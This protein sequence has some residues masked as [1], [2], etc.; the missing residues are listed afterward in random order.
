MRGL[1]S[2]LLGLALVVAVPWVASAQ[3]TLAGVVRDSSGAVL[4]GVTVEASS[5]VLIEKARTALTDDA[6]RYQIID[7]RPGIYTVTFTLT[8]FIVVRRDGVELTGTAVTTANADLRV[9]GVQETITVTGETP[10]VDL[11]ST[12]RQT[13]MGQEI[14]TAIPTSRNS[15]AVAVLI[16]AV[17]VSNGFGP[18]QDVGGALG[19]T[20]LAL[21]AHGSRVSDQRLMVNGVALSTMI[22]GGWG[23]GAIPNATGTAEF[24]IDT[25]AVDAT[26]ATGGVR[27]NFIPRDG[28]NRFSGTIAAAFATEG[29]ASDN[30]TG[31]D[32]GARGLSAPGNIKVNG[33][34]NPGAGGPLKRDSLWFFAS[35]R[36][37]VADLY[38]P[39]MF[40]NRNANDP[41]AWTYVADT[42]RPAVAPREFFVYQ[43]RLTWQASPKNKVGVTFDWESNCFCPDNVSA[44]RT[45]E[46]GT[47]RR[48][49]LQRFVQLDWA[50][51]VSS[52]LLLEASGIHRVERWG[53]M[54]LQTGNGGVAP[55]DPR[56]VGVFDSSR[57][58][59]YRAA[60]QGLAPGS[61]PYNN[62]WNENLHYRAAM[63]YVPGSHVF[64]VGF[65]NAWGYHD[66]ESYDIVPYFYTFNGTTPAA[67]TIRSTPYTTKVE[68]N[69]DLGIFAQDKWTTGRWT[70]AGG[71]RYDHFKNS[72]PEQVLGPSF[73]TP[74]RNE[75]FERIENI[76]WH[77]ITPKLGA[78]YDVFGNGRTAVKATL[79]KYLLGY[80]TFAFGENGLSSAPN[81]IFRLVN[82]A[83]R[84]WH[85]DDRDY[86]PDCDLRTFAANGE[87]DALQNPAFGT[88]VPG[89]SYDPDLL[90]G[91]GKR[92]Y[93]WEFSVGVQQEVVPRVSADVSY[94]RRSYGNFQVMDDRSVRP[95]D[96]DRFTFTA[97]R[98]PRLPG[99]GGYTLTAMDLKF[100][101]VFAPQDNFVT[102]A[103]TYG[104]Q[105]EVWQ[106]VDV[107]GTTRL[108]NG[109][110]LFGGVSTGRLVRDDCPIVEK[111][112]ETLHDFFGNT[113]L[114]FFAARPVELCHRND[115][116][117][118][119]VKGAGAYLIPAIDVQVSAA[120]QSYPGPM[121]AGNYN[122]FGTGTLGR[123]F[124][125]GPFRA[126]QIV[127]SGHYG[128][129]L[130]QFDFRLSKILRFGG[131]RTQVNFDFY[132]LFNS[133]A[134]LTENQAYDFFRTPTSILQA[135]F[136]KLG[137]QFDF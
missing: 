14:V 97:P 50:S 12:T 20:T 44:L 74:T 35:G 58:L 68:V 55:L 134:V 117:A 24:A 25:A 77:D 126:F 88:I 47:D 3:A 72:F 128:E 42:S 127:E 103:K 133:N 83:T 115:G 76:S 89:T 131:T 101:Q 26:L 135:R 62:S 34:F 37:Q 21:M 10:I 120:F 136:F 118:T 82:N 87:C 116:F 54:H 92:Q 86:V 29:F 64:K 6:G 31:S 30:Y 79:N 28:G 7:L 95:A 119:Q 49:P 18:Q 110:Y 85:D 27:T 69:R 65:N 129:R 19:P 53:G 114:F 45:P 22:G 52:K 2:V 78:T 90:T 61:P 60:A 16:P 70:L 123:P 4:P 43:G 57:G 132:N 51:P 13:V 15:F 41:N 23:G 91:W 32:L 100:P 66:N 17:T 104:E 75:R 96:Y 102:L 124:G 9:G 106:G 112:P 130:N 121:I 99:G 67:I 111:L 59:T 56:M 108:Q 98:D 48:F 122:S 125:F 94:F 1:K 137:V 46:A 109:I 63:S 39:G 105:S 5:P 33:D 71:I 11:Q 81:P 36:Y 80:G 93:N 107:T 73:F 8:G 84:T 40:H 38:V 113:R